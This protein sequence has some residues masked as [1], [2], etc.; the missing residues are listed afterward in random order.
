MA[1]LQCAAPG[2][3]RGALQADGVAGRHSV[4]DPGSPQQL[5][6]VEALMT[7]N[8]A[9]LWDGHRIG[10]QPAPAVAIESDALGYSRQPNQQGRFK[11]VLQ[12][13]G[14]IES[15]PAKLPRQFPFCSP[16]AKP[17]GG[18]V[19]NHAVDRGLASVDIGHPGTRQYDD[20]RLAAEPTIRHWIDAWSPDVASTL[21]AGD[22]M[23]LIHATDIWY[24]VRRHWCLQAQRLLKGST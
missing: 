15:L 7:R 10:E 6:V 18:M 8:V 12:Q 16:A 14:T 24:S 17:A 11:G 4:D 2:R 21:P 3:L 9:R 19:A 20:L 23:N 5:Q 1:E 22:T 13:D